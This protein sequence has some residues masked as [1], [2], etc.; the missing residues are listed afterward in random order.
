MSD[1]PVNSNSNYH[2]LFSWKPFH[3]VNTKF[4]SYISY[5]WEDDCIDQLENNHR[6]C[7]WCNV[8]FQGITATKYLA[9]IIG[10]KCMHI[11][12]FTAPIDQ[13][14]ISRCRELQQ[15]KAN[16]KGILNDYSQKWFIP[17]HTYRISHQKLLN[18]IFR[19][20]K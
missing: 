16:K 19:V 6:K 15:I 4:L 8:I 17:Y 14:Y 9:S 20:N 10:T 2:H 12:I 1:P 7:L 11:K 5:I 3:L 18:Q 13:S